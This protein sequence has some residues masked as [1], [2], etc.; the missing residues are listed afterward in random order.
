MAKQIVHHSHL[1]NRLLQKSADSVSVIDLE[2]NYQFV[3]ERYLNQFQINRDRIIGLN[4]FDVF[5]NLNNEQTLTTYKRV[6]AGET[7]VEENVQF[8][9]SDGNSSFFNIELSPWI[10]QNNKIE[11]IILF[12]KKIEHNSRLQNICHLNETVLRLMLDQMPAAIAM[13]DKNMNYL[14]TSKRFL[15]DYRINQDIIGKFHYDVFP[16]IPEE[17]KLLHQRCLA[18]ET[19]S[20][21][22]D[23]FPRLDGRADWVNWKF[24]PWYQNNEIGGIVFFSEVITK[25]KEAEIALTQSNKSLK[26]YLQELS[27]YKYALDES[28]I[29]DIMDKN[30][31]ITY[32]NDNFCKI[33]KYKHEELIFK[34]Y[35]IIYDPYHS[36]EFI[37]NMWSTIQSGKIWHGEIK[38]R[39]KDKTNYWLNTTFVPFLDEKGSP[40]QYMAIRTDITLQ[41]EV[42]EKLEKKIEEKTMAL[43][44]SLV[45]EKEL[46]ELKNRF[47][48]V[49]SH[50]I[51]TPLNAIIGFTNLL[52][53]KK[54]DT[55]A[56][57]YVDIIQDS[58]ENLLTI[59]NDIL[60]LSKIEAGM[61]RLEI[62]SFSPRNLINSVDAMMKPKAA[63]KK[64]PLSFTIDESIPE[65]IDGDSTRLIQILVNLIVNAIKFTHKGHIAISLNNKCIS[66]KVVSVEIIVT[67]TGI[68][69]KPDKLNK[70]FERFE[71][72]EDYVSRKYG[73][74]GLGLSIVK[75]LVE[76]QNGSIEVESEWGKGTT[77]KIV[78]PYIIS[79]QL[80]DYALS[81]PTNPLPKANFRNITILV[82]EDND[83][84]QNLITHIFKQWNLN[85]EL[86]KNGH[87]A[88]QKLK[89]KKY[90]IIFLDIQM[91]VMDG[92][93]A[94]QE[95]R[96]KL[97]LSTPIIAMTA[98][99][100]LGEK[101]KC[102]SYGMN[103]F[104]SKP[105]RE[106]EMYQLI[107]RYAPN[108]SKSV[109]YRQPN[110]TP[111][112]FTNTL[113]N[114]K[115]IHEIS[116]GD[117]DY[118]KS[119]T[120][121]FIKFL[122]EHINAIKLAWNQN[123]IFEMRQVVHNMRSTISVMGLNEILAPN[124]N[125][126]E[127]E[128]IDEENFKLYFE[129]LLNIAK[130]SVKEAKLF[131]K[132][133][134]N[135]NAT[136]LQSLNGNLNHSLD[137]NSNSFKHS[138]NSE[139]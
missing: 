133:L 78:I 29:V 135:I 60:D 81:E 120:K 35:R 49:T 26:K 63:E 51:R 77:F 45:K 76:L 107:S 113:I 117:I 52:Q 94:A 31:L 103:D 127:F 24:S 104:I 9:F 83:I 40:Y 56:N 32:A 14:L 87:E 33:T 123:N 75:E 89:K 73:G 112:K 38:I 118:E 30:G 41:K 111:A 46:N 85:F 90:D 2:M 79:Q 126:L 66:S 16:D 102:I 129:M 39:A 8:H 125:A 69:I 50:E 61:M 48:S 136:K 6:I 37:R 122:P 70:I 71:Q 96:K 100:M 97:K 20:K 88:I 54:L 105:L 130:Q 3:N 124:L 131:L 137:G 72:A 109:L 64:L 68:G 93:T 108:A 57:E 22:E 114:L 21:N 86:G 28:S 4:H 99:A 84:N 7:V 25:Y 55:E 139:L 138:S 23:F 106:D 44:E 53:K 47:I 132:T 74:T 1:I 12:A 15:T 11:G 98:H 18:G 95:I 121:Q 101:E 58:S 92:Y 134:K 62:S 110:Q 17:W 91:P 116:R 115:Y 27:A 19:I 34:D 80:I 67:D 43:N 82:I 10:D 59:I 65:L 13:F 42:E 5:P 36:E 119:V 128:N